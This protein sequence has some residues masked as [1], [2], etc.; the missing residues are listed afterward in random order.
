VSEVIAAKRKAFNKWKKSKSNVDKD[1]YNKANKDA[2]RVVAAAQESK[3]QEFSENLKSA[4]A[5][6]KLFGVVKQMV[7]KNRDVVGTACIRNKEQKVLTEE[8]EIKKVWKD[9][10]ENLL[11]EEFEWDRES[12]EIADHVIG[13]NEMCVIKSQ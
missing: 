9:Y 11:N 8:N 4:E 13:P 10:Y 6:G 5:K 7:K 12:L 1:A 2:K 3:R